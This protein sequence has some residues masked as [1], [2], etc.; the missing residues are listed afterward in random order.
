MAPKRTQFT[1]FYSSHQEIL[2]AY[3][4]INLIVET[5]AC[6]SHVG[7]KNLSFMSSCIK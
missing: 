6:H 5:V 4:L 3:S 7:Q 2:S 1:S